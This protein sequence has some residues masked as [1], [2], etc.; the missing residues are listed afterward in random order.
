[1]VKGPV[2]LTF[3]AL[4]LWEMLV[5]KLKCK[6]IIKW[7]PGIFWGRI[8][9][10]LGRRGRSEGQRIPINVSSNCCGYFFELSGSLIHWNK[11]TIQVWMLFYSMTMSLDRHRLWRMLEPHMRSETMA[12]KAFCTTETTGIW[13]WHIAVWLSCRIP[14]DSLQT[15]SKG[16]ACQAPQVH[17]M[18]QVQPAFLPSSTL[19]SVFPIHFEPS[20]VWLILCLLLTCWRSS[21]LLKSIRKSHCWSQVPQKIREPRWQLVS[22]RFTSF[23]WGQCN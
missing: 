5:H 8:C 16:I 23:R 4:K 17:V 3:R 18:P 1:M 20:C 19:A 10:C 21:P 9:W 12:S 13:L 2:N 6:P 15:P 7:V 22:K 14:N 11:L